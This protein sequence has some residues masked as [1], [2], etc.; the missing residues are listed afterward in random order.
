M[1]VNFLFFLTFGI[2]IFSISSKFVQASGDQKSVVIF[3]DP[4]CPHTCDPSSGKKGILV[5]LAELFLGDK[6]IKVEYKILNWAR[7]IEQVRDGKGDAIAGAY[8]VDAEDFVFPTIEQW[9]TKNCFFAK[10]ETQLDF[11]TMADLKGRKIGIIQDYTYGSPIDDSIQDKKSGIIFEKT[12]GTKALESNV[13]KVSAGRLQALVEETAVFAYA[14]AQV[15][16]AKG[17]VNKGCTTPQKTYL[18]FSP[19]ASKVENS[20]KLAKIVSE[21]MNDPKNAEKIKII[22]K[23][24]GL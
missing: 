8:I 21:G 16:E 11:K 12:S 23:K 1:R 18:A 17:L 4:W 20:K 5:D 19:H 7:S 6:G 3:A 15:T 13:K 22:L 10:P 24:Y 14:S 2:S 9:N